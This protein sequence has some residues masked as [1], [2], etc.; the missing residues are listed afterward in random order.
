MFLNHSN[1]TLLSGVRPDV[2]G[3]AAPGADGAR[4]HL[5][6]HVLFPPAGRHRAGQPH[7]STLHGHPGRSADQSGGR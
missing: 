1:P 4:D 3:G 7:R 5:P 6:P 2:G